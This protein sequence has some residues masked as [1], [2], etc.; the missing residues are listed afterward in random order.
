[1]SGTVQS[2][3]C[4]NGLCETASE[5]YSSCAADCA[6]GDISYFQ[7][8]NAG[9]GGDFFKV[10]AKSNDLAITQM[11][12]N[13]YTQG[14]CQFQVFTKM[15]DF[16]GFEENASAWTEVPLQNSGNAACT[17]WS[18][19]TQETE[20]PAF[21]TPVTIKAG[22]YQSFFVR[23]LSGYVIYKKEGSVGSITVEND[24]L[25]IYTGKRAGNLFSG[26]SSDPTKWNG[27]LAYGMAAG[28]QETVRRLVQ[29]Y[30]K[31]NSD[32]LYAR[33]HQ[34]CSRRGCRLGHQLGK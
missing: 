11:N 22:Q 17:N 2:G 30:L 26:V 31:N 10:R 15:G 34:P 33:V 21:N 13:S 1:M 25:T 12:I 24:D 28:V 16:V 14:S 4:G 9:S 5:S 23:R 29:I 20:L 6:S 18:G 7:V 3:C 19:Q 8:S 27:R 32:T